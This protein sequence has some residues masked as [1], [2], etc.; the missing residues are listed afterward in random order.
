MDSQR[1]STGIT[2]RADTPGQGGDFARPKVTLSTQLHSRH[3][4]GKYLLCPI[5]YERCPYMLAKDSK[6]FRNYAELKYT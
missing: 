1:H 2:E 4:A 6:R 3:R 5:L